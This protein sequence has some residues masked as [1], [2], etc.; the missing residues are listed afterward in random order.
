MARINTTGGRVGG[1][2]DIVCRA[3][4]QV[5]LPFPDNGGNA[6]IHTDHSFSIFNGNDTRGIFAIIDNLASLSGTPIILA[7]IPI[8]EIAL[9]APLSIA[10]AIVTQ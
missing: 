1:V 2:K 9:L 7:L 4:P 3:G 6:I 8:T 10:A 5:L